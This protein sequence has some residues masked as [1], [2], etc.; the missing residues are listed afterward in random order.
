MRRSEPCVFELARL[1]FL[2]PLCICE[3]VLHEQSP[4]LQWAGPVASQNEDQ[5]HRSSSLR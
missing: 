5:W 3:V 4:M 2:L 1:G